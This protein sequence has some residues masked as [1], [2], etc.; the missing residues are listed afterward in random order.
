MIHNLINAL[1][2]CKKYSELDYILNKY[3]DSDNLQEKAM[4]LCVLRILSNLMNFETEYLEL[5]V[6]S[7]EYLQ[8]NN[9]KYIKDILRV[10]N[11]KLF[12]MLDRSEKSYNEVIEVLNSEIIKSLNNILNISIDDMQLSAQT[13]SVLKTAKIYTIDDIEKN[14]YD[15]SLL[16]TENL[17]PKE[18]NEI[19]K[20]VNRIY[21]FITTYIFNYK[22]K[23]M[24]EM[25]M[26]VLDTLNTREK[27]ILVKRFGLNCER[28]TLEKIGIDYGLS[29][30]RIRQIE[31]KALRKLKHPSRE[32]YLRFY[33]N[34][35]NLIEIYGNILSMSYPFFRLLNKIFIYNPCIDNFDYVGIYN[36]K[37][38]EAFYINKGINFSL[39]NFIDTSAQ[40]FNTSNVYT[41]VKNKIKPFLNINQDNYN[42]FIIKLLTDIIVNKPSFYKRFE[43][44]ND[45]L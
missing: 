32:K 6:R 34:P 42:T 14:I 28:Y 17:S 43:F 3:T 27:D 21:G 29:K 22:H 15:I 38:E 5:S 1:T 16:K 25:I 36:K 33:A 19:M 35:N 39:R 40:T 24:E 41:S 12:S 11:D 4:E 37:Q 8:N 10:T 2:H 18:Y 9:I 20:T 26:N 44:F 31:A 45:S 7:Q 13:I 23:S 30:E